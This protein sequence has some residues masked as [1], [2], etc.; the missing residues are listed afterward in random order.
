MKLLI[1]EDELISRWIL[2]E[3]LLTWGY[4]V[5]A[6]EDGKSAWDRYAEGDHRI[7]ISDWIMPYMSGLEFCRKI[8]S[9][10]PQ[11]YCYFI[12]LTTQGGKDCFLEGM[13]AGVDDYMIKPFDNDQLR[14]RLK[15]AER[16]L[17]SQPC[18]TPRMTLPVCP[19]CNRVREDDN[20]WR[21]MEEY[22]SIHTNA[23]LDRSLCPDCS[24]K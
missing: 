18:T 10:S 22:I 5:T 13:D 12:L 1:A 3:T 11:G 20:L 14:A 8:R 6:C 23:G 16:M 17:A 4:D 21:T 2:K 15:V 7:V 19:W 24:N 9:A